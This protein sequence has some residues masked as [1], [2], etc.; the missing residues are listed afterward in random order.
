MADTDM[1]IDN[2]PMINGINWNYALMHLNSVKVILMTIESFCFNADTDSAELEE[3]LNSL[4]NSLD[5]FRIKAHS[6]KNSAMLLGII[7]LYGMAMFLEISADNNDIAAIKDTASHFIK[8]WNNYS[9]ILK[10]EFLSEDDSDKPPCD[11]DFLSSI[12]SQLKL[13]I[14]DFDIS[15]ADEICA[16]LKKYSYE[17]S[18]S[19]LIRS[20]TGAI[21]I[22]DTDNALEV[23]TEIEVII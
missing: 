13:A 14:D 21:N 9:A 11:K 18:V 4:D 5:S 22:M 23:I 12:L 16:E 3:Y 7:P 17:A 19:E 2:L 20:L 1:T 6:M 15:L 8:L 10:Q